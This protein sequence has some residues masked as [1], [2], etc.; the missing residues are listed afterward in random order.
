MGA[1]YIDFYYPNRYSNTAPRK[2]KLDESRERKVHGLQ[3]L[4]NARAAGLLK[5]QTFAKA[6]ARKAMGL[7]FLREDG[8]RDSFT[9]KAMTARLPIKANPGKPGG[10]K[11]WAGMFLVK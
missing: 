8:L 11:L 1:G 10:A 6:E 7:K 4:M 5:E 2:G 9:L 3:H